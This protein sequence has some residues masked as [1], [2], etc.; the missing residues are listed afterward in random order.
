MFECVTCFYCCFYINLLTHRLAILKGWS[1]FSS[2]AVG[3]L[4]CGFQSPAPT[5]VVWSW[6]LKGSKLCM[7]ATARFIWLCAWVRYWPDRDLV[8]EC[9]TCCYCCFCKNVGCLT[10]SGRRFSSPLPSLLPTPSVSLPTP[11]AT[12]L[13][14]RCHHIWYIHKNIQQSLSKNTYTAF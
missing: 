11:L 2:N 8:F 1:T 12:I 10:L 4:R 5:F 3:E 13:Q 7:A 14:H 9:V 6:R